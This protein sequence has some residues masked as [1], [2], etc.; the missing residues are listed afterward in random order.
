MRK[1][2]SHL[3]D[4]WGIYEE[5]KH[6]LGDQYSDDKL[7]ESANRLIEVA[8]GKIAK[9]KTRGRRFHAYA[10]SCADTYT[11]MTSQPKR[12]TVRAMDDFCDYE[13]DDYAINFPA[14]RSKFK[15]Y[16]IGA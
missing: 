7:L 6:T 5:L 11:M 14:I 1:I 10:G 4:V 13:D 9:E 12:E 3:D 2:S 16:G 15:A 8:K